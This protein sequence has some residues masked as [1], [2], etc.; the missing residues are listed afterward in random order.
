MSFYSAPG[1]LSGS[2][3]TTFISKKINATDHTHSDLASSSSGGGGDVLAASNNIFSGNNTFTG[4]NV[5]SDDVIHTHFVKYKTYGGLMELLFEKNNDAS[6]NGAITYDVNSDADGLMSIRSHKFVV[7]NS[8]NSNG[9]V[10][11]SDVVTMAKLPLCP[12]VPSSNDQ[13]VNK[14]YV[15]SLF[16]SGMIL[17]WS[18]SIANIPSGWLLCDGNNNTPNLSGKF[19]LGYGS[20]HAKAGTMN[21]NAED[22]IVE[23][24][25]LPPIVH[26]DGNSNAPR[27]DHPA[28][29]GITDYTLS[30][31]NNSDGGMI[32]ASDN[33]V[34]L[35]ANHGAASVAVQ[36]PYYP[37]Y[38]VLAYI[39]KT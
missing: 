12:V 37:P 16:T 3:N 28:S 7:E 2:F 38:Y 26:H 19:I 21:N 25:H 30:Y 4:Q 22:K 6:T 29:S 18:G 8:N 11:D 20:G 27:V 1:R 9:F 24:T 35:P 33:W 10:M 31:S 15:D 36:E 14:L 32:V 39:I 34:G 13:L 5:F 17:I 23:N